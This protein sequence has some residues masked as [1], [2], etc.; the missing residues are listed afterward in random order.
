MLVR[1]KSRDSSKQFNQN[2][3]ETWHYVFTKMTPPLKQNQWLTPRAPAPTV[4]DGQTTK[5]IGPWY[6]AQ[7]MM[8]AQ[9]FK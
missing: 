1:T 9:G 5:V 3:P 6:T 2:P 4:E 8:K 7:N